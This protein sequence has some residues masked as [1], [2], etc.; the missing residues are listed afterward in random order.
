MITIDMDNKFD[1]VF[2]QRMHI[3]EEELDKQL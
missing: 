1:Q 3:A 2:S